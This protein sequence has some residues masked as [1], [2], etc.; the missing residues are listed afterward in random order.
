MQKNLGRAKGNGVAHW[1]PFQGGSG[2]PKEKGPGSQEPVLPGAGKVTQKG[3][4][5]KGKF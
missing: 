5:S 3:F 1:E 2:D 4:N